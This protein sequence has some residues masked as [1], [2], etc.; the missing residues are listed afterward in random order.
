MLVVPAAWECFQVLQY[1]WQGELG[2][3]LWMLLHLS[4]QK[5]Q[6]RHMQSIK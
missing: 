6:S 1:A 2:L 4:W 3:L 5:W